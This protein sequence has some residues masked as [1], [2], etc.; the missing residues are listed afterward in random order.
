MAEDSPDQELA[1][2]LSA[3]YDD[4]LGHVMFSYPW[5]TEMSIQIVPL[6]E[7]YRERFDCEYGPDLWACEFLDQVGLEVSKRNFNGKKPVAPIRFSTVSGHEIGKTTLV[8]WLI[9]WIMDTRPFCK[10]TVTAVTDDQLRTKTWAELGKW[11]HMSPTKHWFTFNASRGN[12][13]MA[14]ADERYSGIWRVDARTCR[15]ER[16][17]SFAGQHA[18]N[19]TS[20]YIFDEA[21]GI[22]DKIYEVREG[23]LSSGE[24][25][26]FDFGNGT[27]NSGRFYENCAG[28][29]KDQYI[30]R[31]IDSRDVT[32]TNKQKIAEDIAVYGEDSDFIRTRWRGLFPAVGACQFMS[33]EDV[34]IAGRREIGETRGEPRVLGVDVARFGDDSTV[35]WPRKGPDARSFSP[36]VAKGLDTDGVV[37]L[38]TKVYR[39]FEALKDR[40][41]AIFIDEGYNP[42][43]LDRLRSLGFPVIG[44]KFGGGSGD[45][46]RYRFK[47]DEMWDQMRQAAKG[48]LC[49]PGRDSDAGSQLFSD[50]TGREYGFTLSGQIRLEPKAE[51]KKR[52]LPS[53]DYADALALTFA[54]KVMLPRAQDG[55]IVSQ[56]PAVE[57]EYNPFAHI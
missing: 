14:S 16:S 18:P 45:K 8:A 28:R 24:P 57:Y 50:L 54:E 55:G 7:K 17:E 33:T 13:S 23:G 15:E 6:P 9:K 25:M 37:A 39:E 40:P 2:A 26:V 53:P 32:I 49:I 48:W 36:T 31:S 46:E 38:V 29:F 4:P 30:T 10:G 20:F 47:V 21:S 56:G 19:S 12:M 43:V 42:G 44:V 5:D 11:H 34:E 22:A 27:R 3:F 51:M 52:G 41:A 1:D 35:V